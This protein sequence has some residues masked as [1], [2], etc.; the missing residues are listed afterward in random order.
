M[1]DSQREF[2]QDIEA[3]CDKGQSANPKT[4]RN[5]LISIKKMAKKRRVEVE[6]RMEELKEQ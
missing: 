4:A 5:Y 1:V 2:L 3:L 6:E